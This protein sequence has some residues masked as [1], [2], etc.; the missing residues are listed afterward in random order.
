MSSNALN[1]GL[2]NAPPAILSD[3]AYQ[4]ATSQIFWGVLG[5]LLLAG[6]VGM[7]LA[8]IPLAKKPAA[9][10]ANFS[11]RVRLWWWMAAVLSLAFWL[12][13]PGITVLFGF[14]SVCNTRADQTIGLLLQ[15]FM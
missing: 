3:S 10:M 13:K 12:G 2:T 4:Q 9:V 1:T 8:R 14:I 7:V 6:L 5:V 11:S 15:A